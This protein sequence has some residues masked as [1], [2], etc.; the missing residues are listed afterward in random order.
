MA[1]YNEKNYKTRNKNDYVID[2]FLMKDEQLLLKSKPNKKAF[3]VS[4]ILFMLPFALIWIFFDAFFIY[5][6]FANKIFSNLPVFIIVFLVVFFLLHLTPFWFW[7]AN[8]LTAWAQYKNVEYAFTNKRIIIKSG[9]ITDIKNIYYSDVES[10][11]VKVGIVDKMFKV[12]DIYIKS[13]QSATAIMDIDA[14]YIV[15]NKIQAIVNDIK[16]DIEYPNALRPKENTG[17]S[18]K[19]NNDVNS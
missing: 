12:G 9:L 7:L 19:Y 17:Y 11:N 1:K 14:P 6:M 13:K 16:T 2:D 4:K 3:I 5:M 10:V 8:T 15:M 18:T